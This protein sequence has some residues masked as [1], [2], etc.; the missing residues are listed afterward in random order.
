MVQSHLIGQ[1]GESL[2]CLYLW[3]QKHHIVSR[4]FIAHGGEIDVISLYSGI[5]H[6]SE[7]KSARMDIASSDLKSVS[8]ETT[9]GL[10]F[11]LLCNIRETIRDFLSDK[12]I[13]SFF[14]WRIGV[15]Y[16]TSTDLVNLSSRVDTAKLQNI[17]RALKYFLLSHTEYAD[18]PVQIDI[19]E[20]L[21]DSRK[22]LSIMR[23]TEQ[24]VTG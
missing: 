21:L 9:I 14:G 16:E 11:A 6:V 15:S 17:Q 18:L 19:I 5:L 3:S 20:V 13:L 12:L 1:A 4:N 2:A 22:K 8:Y 7:V 24:V 23:Y 10:K